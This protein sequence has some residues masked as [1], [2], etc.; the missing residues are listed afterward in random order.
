[1]SRVKLWTVESAF[2]VPVTTRNSV[3]RPANGSA[4]V[5]HTKAQYDV[6]S[7]GCTATSS[8][9]LT[10]L[11]LV[12]R[13]AGDGPYDTTASRNGWT[14]MLTVADVQSTGNTLRARTARRSPATSS[15]CVSVPVSKNFSISASS[16]S[17]TI[18][19]SASRA[20]WAL[21]FRPAG[22]SPSVAL[23]LPSP[24]KVTAFRPTRSTTPWKAFSSPMGI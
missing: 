14:P 12:G 3:M 24:A 21:S 9:V 7:D 5:F 11:A 15:S 13:S 2:K 20:A 18:S 8:P 23:P 6:A 1:M 4:T 10:C 17:A 16:A 22:M 19:T